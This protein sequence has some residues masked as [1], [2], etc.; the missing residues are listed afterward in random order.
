MTTVA[1]WDNAEYDRLEDHAD[2]V[3]RVQGRGRFRCASDVRARR[4]IAYG[5][6]LTECEKKE[7]SLGACAFEVLH[8]PQCNAESKLREPSFYSG[9]SPCPK[10]DCRTC[11]TSSRTTRTATELSTGEREIETTCAHC[12]FYQKRYDIIPKRPP[13]P[14]PSSSSGGFGGGSSSGGGG[15]GSSWLIEPGSNGASAHEPVPRA[16]SEYL[17]VAIAWLRGRFGPGAGDA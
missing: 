9:Y 12:A 8:C 13:R 1:T 6:L 5:L 3:R 10:C 14:P 4:S 16:P 15:A 17:Q 11:S 7:A 2:G